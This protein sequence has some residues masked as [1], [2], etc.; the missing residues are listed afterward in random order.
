MHIPYLTIGRGGCLRSA[1]YNRWTDGKKGSNYSLLHYAQHLEVED[2]P[3]ALRDLLDYSEGRHKL[4]EHWRPRELSRDMVV[5][6]NCAIED[7]LIVEG[8]RKHFMTTVRKLEAALKAENT[9][10]VDCE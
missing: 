4:N 6:V 8:L 2:N 7:T 3:Q 10:D 9:L 5:A 1:L